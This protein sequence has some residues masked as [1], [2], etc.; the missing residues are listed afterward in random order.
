MTKLHNLSLSVLSGMLL[1]A[2]GTALA[3][4]KGQDN[5]GQE[6]APLQPAAM[7]PVLRPLDRLLNA[8]V[9]V[10]GRAADAEGAGGA[11]AAKRDNVGIVS[12]LVIDTQ[13]QRITFASVHTEDGARAVPITSLAWDAA[14]HAW[15]LANKDD[16]MKA[17]A[18]EPQRLDGLHG[19]SASPA[20]AKKSAGGTEK[21]GGEKSGESTGG[22][23]TEQ[24]ALKASSADSG[25]YALATDCAKREVTGSDGRFGSAVGIVIEARTGQLAFLRVAANGGDVALPWSALQAKKT[26]SPR[27]PQAYSVA[28]TKEKLEGAPRLDKDATSNIDDAAFR[29]KLYEYFGVSAP[30]FDA[31]TATRKQ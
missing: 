5:K 24:E 26:A 22:A 18:F 10:A 9:F 16:L 21:A 8:T 2:G 13:G 7:G 11:A 25:R 6:K 30:A 3:Q 31:A 14:S 17:K 27:D 19:A 20:A 15:V 28:M 23:E 1:V 12:N 29:A 4:D